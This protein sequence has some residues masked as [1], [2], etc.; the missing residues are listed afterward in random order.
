MMM[1]HGR[2]EMER[3]S[4]LLVKDS[5]FNR[6]EKKSNLIFNNIQSQKPNKSKKK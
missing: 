4:L 3:K 1:S 5:K 2:L 6:I